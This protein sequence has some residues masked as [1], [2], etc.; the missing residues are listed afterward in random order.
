MQGMGRISEEVDKIP[1]YKRRAPGGPV[2][3]KAANFYLDKKWEREDHV[4]GNPIKS[5]T[6]T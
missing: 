4:P 1:D 3:W 6:P 5:S 2:T